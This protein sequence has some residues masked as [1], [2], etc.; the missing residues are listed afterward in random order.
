MTHKELKELLDGEACRINSKAFIADDPVQFPR[1]FSRQDDIEVASLLASTVA[2][3]NRK[4]ICRNVDR[5]MSMMAD[6]PANFIREGAYEDIP[7]DQNIHRT[8]FGRNLKHWSRGLKRIFEQYG[9]VE[10]M[11]VSKGINRSDYGAWELAKALNIEL[12]KA[13]D[14]KADSRCLPVNTESS[15]LKRLNMALRW[16]VRNDGI[17]DLGVWQE[18]RPSQLYIPMDVHVGNV[19]RQLGMITRKA[20]DAK[21]VFELTEVC[22]SMNAEDPAIYDFA[23][24]G[25]GMKL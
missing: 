13:N 14:G 6:D 19:S 10:G 4:M 5:L 15:A 20:T 17:V 23:L 16:L 9:T 7:D 21:A 8:F 2:W 1:R 11:T 18:W 3:G 25:I 24:F 22:R 12:A